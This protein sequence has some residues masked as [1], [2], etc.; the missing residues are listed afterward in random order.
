MSTRVPDGTR[1]PTFS[2]MTIADLPTRA[3]LGRRCGVTS[4]LASTSASSVERK[5]PPCAWNCRATSS[6]TDWSTT[7][8][9]GDEHSTP[10]SKLLP[11]RMSWAAFERSAEASM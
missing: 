2:A 4:A 9:L 7:T 5:C 11:R 1:K 6:A 3:V 10:L 8:E